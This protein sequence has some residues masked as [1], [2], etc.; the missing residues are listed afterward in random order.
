LLSESTRRH[1]LRT[2]SAAATWTALTETLAAQPASDE[3]FWHV[4]KRQFPLEEG[5]LYFNAANVC[6]ASRAVLDRHA[7]YLR[8]FQA[9]P[10]FQNRDKYAEL[11]AK[12]RARTARLLRARPDE[13]A[14]TR[15]TSEG[16]NLIVHGL[17]L[18]RGDEVIVHDH[19]HPSNLDSWLV[20]ASREGFAVRIL[21]VTFP[22]P[23][24]AALLEPIAKAITPQTKVIATT[25]VTNTTGLRFPVDE[26]GKLAQ[27][28][29]IWFHLDGAQS[30]GALDVDVTA[31]GCDSYAASA[32]KW[33]MG[34]LEAGVLYVRAARAAQVWPSIVSA[35]WTGRLTGSARFEV[36]GQ[37]DDARLT[38]LDAALD[39]LELF[40]LPKVE[41]RVRELTI[42]LKDQ[43]G[44][45]PGVE[46]R[47]N[48]EPELSGGVVK[49]GL[50]PRNIA[51]VYD[52]LYQK[53][54][55]A[56]AMT[57]SGPTSGL[58]FSPHVYN[59]LDDAARLVDAVR[60]S[61]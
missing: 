25:H 57:G 17:D 9:N 55:V 50:G 10:S 40:G 42:Y 41:A 47:T 32:H 21:P 45:L 36:F 31:V 61:L 54:R 15:N 24:R 18:K 16:T 23:S 28:R 29:G 60:Q 30:F 37:R 35:G 12:V 43:L 56:I 34:P 39:F 33:M 1:W 44:R 38:A 3:A 6:P 22:A 13:I 58:R 11:H 48:R 2:A 26:I 49:L 7:A 4:V 20:R 51:Q 8:D 46:M 5:L 19:N 27:Q 53:H 59:T 52:A 14:L